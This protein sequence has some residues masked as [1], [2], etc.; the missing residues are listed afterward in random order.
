MRKTTALLFTSV[1]LLSACGVDTTGLSAES[2][3][4]AA[5]NPS[6][7]VVVMEFADLQCP[8]CKIAY[9]SLKK[10]LLEKYGNRVR[11]EFRHFPLQSIHRYA[12]SLAEG[13]E[14]AADQGKFWEF[15]EQ[16]YAKQSQ[17]TYI[18]A[19]VA[20]ELKLD[21]ELFTRCTKSHIKKPTI[22]SEYDAG[23]KM[24]VQGTPTF[25]V[26]GKKV[27]STMDDLSKAI[28]AAERA[29]AAQL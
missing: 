24:Q 11:F 12:M 1:L 26:N 15:I 13:S 27:P 25:F 7:S 14:C 3:R 6:S 18:G 19:A 16:A 17:T 29:G 4:T 10:P 8:A 5:G 9:E 23:I 2:T 21:M 28:E 20:E 22:L